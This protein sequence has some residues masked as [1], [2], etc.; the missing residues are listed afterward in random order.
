MTY[1]IRI[2]TKTFLSIYAS[3]TL[4]P[5]LGQ[6]MSLAHSFHYSHTLLYTSHNSH[7]LWHTALHQTSTT[8]TLPA[9]HLTQFPHSLPFTSHNSH[10]LSHMP[11]TLTCSHNSYT[12]PTT[13]TPSATRLTQPHINCTS[14]SHSQHNNT[15]L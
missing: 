15:T 13:H 10:S 8:R 3:I 1:V 7:T 5:S 11:P 6:Y 9:T 14:L 12:P 4:K 2:R